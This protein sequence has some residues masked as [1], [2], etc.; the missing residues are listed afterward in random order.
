ML[1]WCVL[2]QDGSDFDE[3]IG[4]TEK[5]FFMRLS[6]MATNDFGSKNCIGRAYCHN[7]YPVTAEFDGYNVIFSTRDRCLKFLEV[8]FWYQIKKLPLI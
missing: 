2:F 5:Q 8:N 3:A 6:L 7:L 1:R 4:H